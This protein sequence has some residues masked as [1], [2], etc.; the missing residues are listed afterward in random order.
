MIN[1]SEVSQLHYYQHHIGDLLRETANL[2]DHQ[3]VTYLRMIWRYYDTE[4]P[5]TENLEDLA[6]A[7]RS[8]EKTVQLLLRHYFIQQDDGW[9]Q[10]RC[11]KEI[12]A[13]HEKGEKRKAA[14][15]ARWKDANAKQEQSNSTISD[16]NHKPI[17][18]NHK[19]D[20]DL[21]DSPS[22][23]KP[24]RATR[25]PNDFLMPEDWKTEALKINPL[26]DIETESAKFCDYWHAKS[27]KDA[28]KIDWLAT[29][30]NWCRNVRG[31]SAGYQ[32]R[33]SS[34]KLEAL[35]E[36]NR[37]HGEQWLRGNQK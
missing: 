5:I 28:T 15:N 17:T 9:H 32:Q 22:E 33:G 23:P 25:L 19:P 18:N 26:I 21:F 36:R 11:D 20:K 30:R 29:W 13:Y 14:A 16:A 2:N 31:P 4:K 12:A 24:K 3:L 37:Q 34:S 6:F 7:M 10:S 27:G 1:P 35:D 8:D